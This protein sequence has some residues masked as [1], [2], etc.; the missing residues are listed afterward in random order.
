VI[1]CLHMI[2]YCV[3][4]KY[5]AVLKQL[6]CCTLIEHLHVTLLFNFVAGAASGCYE[7]AVIGDLPEA[8]AKQFFLQQFNVSSITDQDWTTVFEVCI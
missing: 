6:Q 2:Y 4:I 3:T 8:D 7:T 1:N 5:S